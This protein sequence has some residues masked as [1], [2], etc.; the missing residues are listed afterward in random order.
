MNQAAGLPEAASD[1]APGGSESP[2]PALRRTLAWTRS[3]GDELNEGALRA[4]IRAGVE[5]SL[6]KGKPA[7]KKQ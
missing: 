4:L 6:A 5:R 2:R 1:G 3:E 7:G